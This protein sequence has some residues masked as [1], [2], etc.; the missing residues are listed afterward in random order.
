MGAYACAGHCVDTAASYILH[1]PVLQTLWV[2]T[3]AATALTTCGAS[4]TSYLHSPQL[5]CHETPNG[6]RAGCFHCWSCRAFRFLN[7]SLSRP[8]LHIVHVFLCSCAWEP[9]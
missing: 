7:P 4:P 9:S 2:V 3:D 8:S 6:E 5:D 1:Q